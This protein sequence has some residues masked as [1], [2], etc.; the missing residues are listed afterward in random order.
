MIATRVI[1]CLLLR[2]AGLVKT[3]KFKDPKYLGDPRNA[4]K[5]YNE[6]EVD[7]LILLDITATPERRQPNFD[8][9]R[10]IVSEAFMPV[11]Y[12]GG[13]QSVED[14][15]RLL[16]VG[17]EKA[18]ICTRAIEDA[19][20]VTEAVRAFGSSTV[21]V[22]MNVKR[23]FFGK[24]EVFGRGARRGAGVDPVTFAKRMEGLGVGEIVV[25]SIDRDGT[26]TGYD[27][28]LLRSVT[29]AVNVPVVAC[30]GAGQLEHFA[31]AVREANVAAVAAGSMF[32]FQGKRR[33]VLI[34][35]P[36]QHEL[37]SVLP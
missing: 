6:R 7:E 8:L 20:L 26:M 37:R 11:A 35:Y 19:T 5:I 16:A 21:V 23:G 31:A 28:E 32:V 25:N 30:G 13:L 36:T 34:N 12:G 24:Y 4:V 27:L 10:E 18:V 29:S 14:I 17:V 9:I 2:G 33:A 1:P 22:C 15:R 3:V